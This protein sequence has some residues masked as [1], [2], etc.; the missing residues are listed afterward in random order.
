MSEQMWENMVK[1]ADA[2]KLKA[3][4]YKKLNL[5]FESKL[6]S[7]PPDIR[8]RMARRVENFVYN[9]LINVLNAQDT[10][11]LAIAKI[12]ESGSYDPGPKAE[13][14]ED[15]GQWTAD[16]IADRASRLNTDKGESGNFDD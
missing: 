16:K 3:G 9:M 10:A 15:P 11:P 2:A 7:Q 4:D 6:L 13:R 5:P 14:I 8:E 1:Y 12:I